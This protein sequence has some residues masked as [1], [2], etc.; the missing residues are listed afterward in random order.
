MG[1]VDEILTDLEDGND[2]G[3]TGKG[4]A[5]DTGGDGSI[6]AGT[7]DSG[8]T[9]DGEGTGDAGGAG[10]NNSDG[11]TGDG[12]TITGDGDDPTPDP[13]EQLRSDQAELRQMLRISRR[14]N[15]TMKAKLNRLGQKPTSNNDDEF[16]DT[17]DD[18]DGDGESK[19]SK[20]EELQ[21]ELQTI[22]ETR[23]A[24][25]ELLAE[26]M[27][28]TQKYADVAEVCSRQ[29]MDD[30]LEAAATTLNEQNGT[31]FNE[32]I[33]ELETSIWSKQNPYKYLYELVKTH[34]PKYQKA[35]TGDGKKVDPTKKASSSIQDMG[36]T[37]D[38]GGG[39]WTAEKID[40]MPEDELH[41]VPAETYDKYL[42]GELDK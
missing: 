10:D 16:D 36:G 18:T 29:N 21:S 3:D 40:A 19:L 37:G 14:E 11:T 7:G 32:L 28:E 42:A 33:L 27:A 5:D 39:G 24:N 9:T 13:I 22:H 1:E 38:K 6:D 25:L 12:A 23:G 17:G 2:T 15:A 30:I 4:G 31:D 41:K 8:T 20:I 35:A 34:H 26:Q